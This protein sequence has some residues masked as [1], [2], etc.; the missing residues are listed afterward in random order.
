MSVRIVE[1]I[2]ACRLWLDSGS[3]LS[4]PGAGRPRRNRGVAHPGEGKGDARSRQAVSVAACRDRHRNRAPSSILRA[5]DSESRAEARR[6]FVKDL[7]KIARMARQPRE[8]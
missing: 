1:E 3:R 5:P 2:L 7:R 6:Q 4:S 8:S